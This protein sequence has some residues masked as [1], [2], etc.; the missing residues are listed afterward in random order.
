MLFTLRY[1]IHVFVRT[2]LNLCPFLGIV[3]K[4]KC[5]WSALFCATMLAPNVVLFSSESRV[6]VVVCIGLKAELL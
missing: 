4:F 3:P 6:A 1:F 5:L 2:G